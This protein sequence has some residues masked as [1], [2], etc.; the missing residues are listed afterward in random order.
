VARVRAGRLRDLKRAAAAVQPS[1]ERDLANAS[2]DGVACPCVSRPARSSTELRLRAK[3]KAGAPEGSDILARLVMA[4]DR[5]NPA[6]QLPASLEELHRALWLLELLMSPLSTGLEHAPKTGP[7]LYVGNHEIY[8]LDVPMVCLEIYEKT[9]RPVRGLA[10][11]NHFAVPGWRDLLT[12]YGGVD[13]TRENC[14]ALFEAG[15]QVLVFPGGGREVM[16]RKGEKYRLI[17]K[18]RIGFARLAIEHGVPIVPF[19]SVGIEDMLEIVLD[20][21]DLLDS[22]LGRLLRRVGVTEQPWFRGGEVVPPITRGVGLGPFPLPR[23]ERLYLHFAPP[24]DTTRL[25][26]RQDDRDACFALRKEVEAAIETG[27]GSLMQR[28][29]ADPE[30]HPIQR[31]LRGLAAWLG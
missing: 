15:E 25:A 21:N 19:A 11:H 20:A 13:G 14:A 28:R 9:G 16:K 7:V 22:L 1:H 12:R 23:P 24:I 6:A 18:H 4:P 3:S 8:G 27:M 2:L 30:R 17:W 5:P 31:F 10:D 26:G 29:E